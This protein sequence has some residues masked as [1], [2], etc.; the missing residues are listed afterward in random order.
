MLLSCLKEKGCLIKGCMTYVFTNYTFIPGEP[1]LPDEMYDEECG[2]CRPMEDVK[3]KRHPWASPGS[4]PVFGEGCGVNGGNP[5]GCLLP[6]DDDR[7]YG[8]CCAYVRLLAH[9]KNKLRIFC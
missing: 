9:Y 6:E 2:N 3:K 1:T 8:A 7:P 4:A 5:N